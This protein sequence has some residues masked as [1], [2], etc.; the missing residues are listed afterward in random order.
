MS[1]YEYLRECL[2][3]VGSA[4]AVLQGKEG[5]SC[6]SHRGSVL[7]RFAIRFFSYDLLN[8]RK[9]RICVDELRTRAAFTSP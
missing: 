4:T 2:S 6:T 8:S 7:T 1:S 9:Q 3:S 5:I